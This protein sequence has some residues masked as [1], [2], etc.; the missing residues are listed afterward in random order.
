MRKNSISKEHLWTPDFMRMCMTNFLFFASFYMLLPA[1]PAAMM[2]RLGL[3]T[4]QTGSMFLIFITGMFAAGP[5]HAYLGDEYKRKHV[6]LYSILVMLGVTVG[7]L[8]VDT[9]LKLLLLAAI[10][11]AAFGLAVTAGITVAIDITVSL[12]RSTGNMAYAMAARLGMI[13]GVMGGVW[14][15]MCMSEGFNVL[16]YISLACGMLSLFFAL[17]VYV[18]FRAPI[19]V[20]Y[21][22]FDRF[23]LLCS[24]LPAVNM[25]LIAFIPGLLI[26]IFMGGYISAIFFFMVLLLLTKPFTKMFVRLSH[27]CQR[28]T[29]NTTC[30]L[31]METGILTGMAVCCFLLNNE[32]IHSMLKDGSGIYPSLHP[33]IDIDM[34]YRIAGISIIVASLFFLLTYRYYKRKRV[35]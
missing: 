4:I 27:H 11:G 24:W 25:V 26:P 19:G 31:A 8:F 33:Y 16:A 32:E 35:R 23:L 13:V 7:Y 6:L 17:R 5:F 28:G 1:L 12:Y 22:N 9:Y 2:E 14:I 34:I 3:S 21:C 30:H 10:Q 20:S 15:W 18:A 29:A